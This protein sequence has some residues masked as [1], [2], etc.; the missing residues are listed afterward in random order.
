MSLSNI[1]TKIKTDVKQA[2][3]YIQWV[4]NTSFFIIMNILHNNM[5]ANCIMHAAICMH[6]PCADCG[7]LIISCF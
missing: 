1:H 3:N 6:L 7:H 4:L 5:E 2:F